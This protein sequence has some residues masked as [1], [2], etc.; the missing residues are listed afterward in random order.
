A[1]GTYRLN[2]SFAPYWHTKAGCLQ[3]SADGMTKLTV[4][5]PGVVTLGFAVTATRAL[6]A[7]VGDGADCR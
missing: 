7:I 5:R 1:P 2:V 3:P 4:R 6:A